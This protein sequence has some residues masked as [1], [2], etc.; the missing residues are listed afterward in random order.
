MSKPSQF[1][2]KEGAWIGGTPYRVVR[3][4]GL[5]GMGEVYE[6]D[7]TRTGT[8][9]AIKVLRDAKDVS[10]NAAVRLTREGRALAVI[11]HPHVVRV[12]EIGAIAD[13]RPYFAMQLLEGTTLRGL[14][15]RERKLAPARALRLMLQALAGLQAV[16]EHGIVHRDVKPT[17]LFVCRGEM[18][19]VLDF[20][21][22]K[23]LYGATMSPSTA[24]GLVLGTM[25]YM[26]PEQLSGAPV[27]CATDVYASALVLFELIAGRHA[28]QG[29]KGSEASVVARLR[30]VAPR[31]SSVADVPLPAAFDD[32][33]ARALDRNPAK[34]YQT[35]AAFAEALRDSWGTRVVIE[36][37]PRPSHLPRKV[38]LDWTSPSEGEDTAEATRVWCPE[39][40]VEPEMRPDAMLRLGMVASICSLVLGSIAV[41]VAIAGALSHAG[42]RS[43]IELPQA[44]AGHLTGAP[45]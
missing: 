25:R 2:L 9:R 20:G 4:L 23:L 40:R 10:G 14:L 31:L 33:M 45:R 11:D 3:P 18:V 7:H 21:V 44:P 24:E 13:G 19:K 30:E 28:F 27:S 43:R 12:F 29:P 35:A 1:S 37:V 32:V 26:A 6:V 38:D 36:R 39:R 15:A 5:G 8:R 41:T 17:N 16:H 22:A 34:R 42:P